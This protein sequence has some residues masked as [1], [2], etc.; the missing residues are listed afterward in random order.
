M[1]TITEYETKLRKLAEF[2]PELANSKE[3]LCSKF[4]EGL[5]L[6]IREKMSIFDSQSYKKVVQLALKVEKLTSE[7]MS[8]GSFQ[9]RKSFG[10]MSG[11][12][13]KKSRSSN[14]FGNSSRFGTGSI[15]SP[16]TTRSP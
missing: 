10:F 14:F 8:R 2:V 4:E 1:K 7:R 13:S 3:Y 5:T 12:S 16:Q 6:E 9:K 11:Q 15:S